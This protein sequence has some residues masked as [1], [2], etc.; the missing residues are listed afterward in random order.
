MP[1]RMAKT[2]AI[3]TGRKLNDKSREDIVKAVSSVFKPLTV[4]A[5]QIGFEV[6]RVTFVSDEDFKRAMQLEGVRLFGL[7]CKILGGGPPITIVHLFDYPFEEEDGFISDVFKDFGEVKGVK[8]QTYL[9]DR[10][11]YTGTRLVSLVLKGSLPRSLTVDGY[12]CRVWY[13][14]QP[15]VCNLCG[16]QG[17]KS[18]A[19]P[20]RDKCRRCGQSGHFA[21][22]CPRT[23]EDPVE[24][25]SRASVIV[26]GNSGANAP[27]LSSSDN[28]VS[29]S[30]LASAPAAGHSVSPAGNSEENVPPP[31][32]A[33]VGVSVSVADPVEDG[34]DHPSVVVEESPVEGSSGINSED[35]YAFTCGQ[36]MPDSQ[37][38]LLSPPVPS[39]VVGDVSSV[40]DGPVGHDVVS[41][42]GVSASQTPSND[43]SVSGS[44]PDPMDQSSSPVNEDPPATSGLGKFAASTFGKLRNRAA[45]K[46]PY[47]KG[48]RHSLP[49]IASDRPSPGQTPKPKR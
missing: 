27:P 49:Q 11:I 7:Y 36:A 34:N 10:S 20:N 35:A 42:E 28:Y 14:G 47:P 32:S 48:S 9:F 41:G 5:V 18:S 38:S 4:V 30:S 13:K 26:A 23:F 31:S 46:T 39:P 29:L 21:R 44:V 15:L 17:H 22:A 2:L 1:M 33:T 6:V 40:T 12:L 43:V 3:Q 45:R 19:C 25:E 16:V 8:K 37:V 24:E